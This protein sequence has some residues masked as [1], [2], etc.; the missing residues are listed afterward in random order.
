MSVHYLCVCMY[1]FHCTRCMH[2]ASSSTH[3][4]FFALHFK[5]DA[6]AKN[7]AYVQRNILF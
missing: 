7:I 2:A 1:M 6:K 3:H 4:N 5:D